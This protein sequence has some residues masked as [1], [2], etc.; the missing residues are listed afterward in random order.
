MTDALLLYLFFI[1][2][3]SVSTYLFDRA[4]GDFLT[5]L[6]GGTAIG[7]ALLAS[8]GFLRALLVGSIA[9]GIL[10]ACVPAACVILAV[11]IQA[12]IR[13]SIASD[14]KA[15]FESCCDFV[16]HPWTFAF[17]L[18]PLV[19]L[20]AFLAEVFGRVLFENQHGLYT[21]FF[22]N[23]GDLPFHLQVTNSFAKG[24]NFPPEDPVL[25]GTPLTYPFLADFLSAILVSSGYSLRTSLFVPNMLLMLSFVILLRR[26]TF[27]LTDNRLAGFLAPLLVSFSGG[28]GWVLLVSGS[29]DKTGHVFHYLL[30]LPHDFTILPGHTWRWGNSLTTLLVPQRSMLF[31]LPIAVLVFRQWWI[32]QRDFLCSAEDALVPSHPAMRRQIAAGILCGLLPLIHTHTFLGVMGVAAGAAVL[33]RCWRLWLAFFI[34]ATL[35]ASPELLW[36]I[37][38]IGS[39]ARVFLAM[40]AGW[41]HGELNPVWFWFLNTGLFIPLL[42]AAL[43]W[44]VGGK[45][46]LSRRVAIYYA[47]FTLCFLVP[48]VIKLAPWEWDNIKVLFLWFVASTPLVAHLLAHW[49]QLRKGARALAVGVLC[50]LTLAG[51]LDLSRVVL[52]T[53]ELRVFDNDGIAIAREITER[54]APRALVLHAPTFDSPVFLTGRRSL[55][56]YP[57]Q[58]WSRGLDSGSR[59]GD[60]RNIYAGASDGRALLERYALNYVLIGPQERAMMPVNDAFFSDFPLIGQSGAYALYKIPKR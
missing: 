25:A 60:I 24:N 41:D 54:T 50:T 29:P 13:R 19:I 45:P 27:E 42:I 55:L 46:L 57:G 56:G 12:D 4:P 8:L 36:L 28:L 6:A 58:I 49:W 22:N 40:H 11:L 43:A 2:A 1:L 38:G 16:R 20:V 17:R 47:P 59:E 15:T 51:L 9:K 33:S 10:L 53:V 31:G 21:G 37:R 23:L 35:T 3:G 39:R 18:L 48:N 30:N 26:W 14:L 7:L 52:H 5:R 44:R 34:A 32:A